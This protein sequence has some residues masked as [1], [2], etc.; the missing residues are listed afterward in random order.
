MV[1][2]RTR[3]REGRGAV[4]AD[5]PHPRHPGLPGSRPEPRRPGRLPASRLRGRDGDARPVRSRGSARRPHEM[6]GPA[7]TPDAAHVIPRSDLV[8]HEPT[9]DC[10]CGPTPQPVK[11]DDGSVGWIVVHA[12]L[13]GR[14]TSE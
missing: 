10:A 12:S 11:R 14:E 5:R 8:V 3:T 9:E 4:A 2:S 13:D 6:A 1:R 7:V